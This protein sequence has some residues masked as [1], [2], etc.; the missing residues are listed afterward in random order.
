MRAWTSGA[1]KRLIPQ[2]ALGDFAYALWLFR[3]HQGRFPRLNSPSRYSDRLFGMKKDGTFLDPIRQ[4]VSDKE[5]VKYYIGAVVGPEHII[6]TYKV[7]RSP[8]E[9]DS[10]ELERFP[11]VLKPTH[12]SGIV[13][14]QTCPQDPLDKKSLRSWFEI[15]YYKVGREQNY[16]YLRPKIIIEE[17]FSEDGHTPPNDYKIF[18]FGGIPKFIQVDSDRHIQHTRNFYN[19][20]WNRLRFTLLYPEKLEDDARPAQLE[21]MLEIATRLSKPFS[22]IRTDMYTNGTDVKVGELTNCPESANARLNPPSAEF[23]LGKLFE[24]E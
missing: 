3:R 16:K 18:C 24:P 21:K 5:Y 1:L 15:D 4:F 2:N 13:Q 8:G 22:F 6:E 7:L 9:V 20:C 10:L 17:F 11:C 23:T 14:I 12:A 19:T